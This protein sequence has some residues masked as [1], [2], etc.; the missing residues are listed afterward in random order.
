M[1][2]DVRIKV[3][4]YQLSFEILYKEKKTNKVIELQLYFSLHDYIMLFIHFL[5]EMTHGSD[6]G[7]SI[8]ETWRGTKKATTDPYNF[9]D[10]ISGWCK[11]SQSALFNICIFIKA[12]N[13]IIDID[14][15]LKV[16]V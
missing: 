16:L 7:Y 8:C 10:P 6:A 4:N 11:F 3:L 12:F 13:I 1:E 14:L 5:R 2:S 9:T 15:T